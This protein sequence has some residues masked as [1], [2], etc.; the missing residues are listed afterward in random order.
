[1]CDAVG[2]NSAATNVLNG[3]DLM[4]CLLLWDRWCIHVKC[5]ESVRTLLRLF[6]Y[7]VKMQLLSRASLCFASAI[8][9]Q[10]AVSCIKPVLRTFKQ[11]KRQN[12]S[13]NAFICLLQ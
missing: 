4:P 7:L 2:W 3:S 9:L 6:V 1:M 12:T 10:L 13:L 11:H 8:Y 5:A